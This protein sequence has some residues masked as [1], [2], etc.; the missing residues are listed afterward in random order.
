MPPTLRQLTWVVTR[1]VNRTVGGGMAAI[2]MLRRTFEARQWID[3]TT[4]GVLVAVSRL[5]PATNILAY[6]AA[7]G[8]HLHR[9]RGAL[10]AVVGASIPAS[11]VVSALAATLVR[12]D[13]YAVV[14]LGLSAGMLV[15][16]ALVLS[17]AWHLL[18]PYL[19]TRTWR[20]ATLVIVIAVALYV[21]GLTPVRVLLVAALASAAL[22][23][24][25]SSTSRPQDGAGSGN[26][27]EAS[28]RA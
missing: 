1:D 18:K 22:P 12:L 17:S 2:E 20:R 13:R 8:W 9:W 19:R 11:L 23:N 26:R 28:A 25:R 5:T 7:A 27:S 14:R 16:A 24:Q 4:H 15:A 3:A 10:L 6:C 21:A